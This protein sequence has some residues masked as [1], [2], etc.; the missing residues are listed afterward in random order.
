MQATGPPENTGV[1]GDATT[2]W[3]PLEP[4]D[5]PEWLEL[6]YAT[7]MLADEVIV[8]ESL[9]SSFVWLVQGWDE[10]G[11]M[12]FYEELFDSTPCGGQLSV[13]VS[14]IGSVNRVRVWTQAPD[15]EEIDAVALIGL[16]L[17]VFDGVGDACDNCP[18]E[19][20]A[21]QLDSDGD[22][23]GDACDACPFDRFNDVD[24][25]EICGDVDNCRDVFNTDQLDSDGDLAGDACDCAPEDATARTPGEVTG[26]LV[27]T[28]DPHTAWLTWQAAAV[29][30]HYTVLRG[31]LSTLGPDSYGTCLVGFLTVT[32][33]G[34]A[35]LPSPGA[36]F[37]YL[38]HG[39]DDQCGP[40]PLGLE[41]NGTSRTNADPGIC[42]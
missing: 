7:P 10:L 37:T 24:V 30:D 12:Q 17:S 19:H 14:T 9:E 26:L 11:V 39:D 31:D 40:G 5:A 21:D 18:D 22:L 2:N 25:D 42:P 27:G 38:V 1:C 6:T 34:D 23:A 32:G 35:E 8:H 33:L 15:W 36:G 20:N 13:P 16:P 29:A 28:T 4:V 3:A 41:S